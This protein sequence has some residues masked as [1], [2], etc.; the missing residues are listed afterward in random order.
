MVGTGGGGGQGSLAT[1]A[2][3]IIRERYRSVQPALAASLLL[4]AAERL[5][6]LTPPPPVTGPSAQGT[7]VGHLLKYEKLFPPR[8]TRLNRRRRDEGLLMIIC[9]AALESSSLLLS[10]LPPLVQTEKKRQHFSWCRLA[11]LAVRCLNRRSEHAI[12]PHHLGP[13]PT[14]LQPTLWLCQAR[15]TMKEDR[16]SC[17]SEVPDITHQPQGC[18]LLTRPSA[19]SRFLFLDC[20]ELAGY[21]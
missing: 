4:V 19:P 13:V 20:P 8:R 17:L 10:L 3:S 21:S 16:A 18:T 5:P 12:T 7:N 15:L 2:G 6:A 11:S 9:G 1:R 14:R